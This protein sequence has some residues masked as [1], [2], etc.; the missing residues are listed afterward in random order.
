[1]GN[2]EETYLFLKQ[3]SQKRHLPQGSMVA[4]E[5]VRT[6]DLVVSRSEV[7]FDFENK[8]FAREEVEFSNR[9]GRA[10]I[11]AG[12]T[13]EGLDAGSLV[14]ERVAFPLIVPAGR[15][16]GVSIVADK[17]KL[18]E[19]QS[20]GS[21]HFEIYEEQHGGDRGERMD[22][23]LT[24][25]YRIPISGGP[26]LHI[27]EQYQTIDCGVLPR[28]RSHKFTHIQPGAANV[29]LVVAGDEEYRDPIPLQKVDDVFS[30]A[31]A[32]DDGVH[33]YYFDVDGKRVLDSN[34]S[35]QRVSPGF[36][37]VSEIVL[38]RFHRDFVIENI[39]TRA[40]DYMVRANEP[41][42]KVDTME[43]SLAP[44]ELRTVAFEIIPDKFRSRKNEGFI[45][46]ISNTSDVDGKQKSIRV[47]AE[48]EVIGPH[49]KVVG[50]STLSF[51]SV[52]RGAKVERKLRL[53]NDGDER[54]DIS[55]V[56]SDYVV[57]GEKIVLSPGEERDVSLTLDSS[58]IEQAGPREWGISL[59]SNSVP[60]PHHIR[61]VECDAAIVTL[62]YSTNTKPP[63]EVFAGETHEC[64]IQFE[65]S[66]SE[67]VSIQFDEKQ[68]RGAL[69]VTKVSPQIIGVK[70]G[71]KRER[72]GQKAQSREVIV[73]DALS[74]VLECRVILQYTVV[75]ARAEG[76]FLSKKTLRSRS[77][78]TIRIKIKNSSDEK[79]KIFKVTRKSSNAFG[80]G[81]T[82]QVL[83]VEKNILDPREQTEASYAVPS[84]L[85]EQ[86]IHYRKMRECIEIESNDASGE[87]VAFEQEFTFQPFFDR[88]KRRVAAAAAAL[89]CMAAVGLVM[90]CLG[91]G[92][93][94][95]PANFMR[96][97]QGSLYNFKGLRMA[98]NEGGVVSG[99]A[100]GFS[101]FIN[102]F[103]AVA[104]EQG[105]DSIDVY[106]QRAQLI[107]D[108]RMLADGTLNQRQVDSI[109][110][111]RDCSRIAS[112]PFPAKGG[113]EL[114]AKLI[115]RLKNE[116]EK[117]NN[118]VSQLLSDATRTASRDEEART[119]LNKTTDMLQFSTC[120]GLT[121]VA[122]AALRVQTVALEKKINA[123]YY[124][125]FVGVPR[126][127]AVSINARPRLNNGEYKFII[128][129]GEQYSYEITNENYY[130]ESGA[131]VSKGNRT[132]EIP[133][134]MK[135][136]E[137]Y[138]FWY[139]AND[140][141][142]Q[143][144]SI[145]TKIAGAVRQL[146]N[147]DPLAPGTYTIHIEFDNGG[148]KDYTVE[149]RPR[150]Q[151]RFTYECDMGK[152]VVTTIPAAKIYVLGDNNEQS[153][154]GSR[155][156]AE[157]SAYY[158]ACRLRLVPI[159]SSYSEKTVGIR[160]S[161]PFEE[162]EFH[163]E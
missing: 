30:V 48:A 47:L 111:E 62:R 77:S 95:T 109:Y 64:F 13:I 102:A 9:G 73:R 59:L 24:I 119:I 103:R 161:K 137:G 108:L 128:N 10:V 78:N 121:D 76:E 154:K 88:V 140:T 57:S 54:L 43:K 40:L 36:G 129:E 160:V 74:D 144:L 157:F 126:G 116:I 18:R 29:R 50:D 80:G 37:N 127:S 136:R 38:R 2:P 91:A 26:M 63:F 114:Q 112:T 122:I 60:H 35:L 55:I 104:S 69:K 12:Y 33:H 106:L 85:G 75:A 84:T 120:V 101:S 44:G 4:I 53:L 79:L 151:T 153:L 147:N 6:S 124:V 28:Y 3:L 61:N 133:I 31:L 94:P 68:Y 130:S 123:T 23:M 156:Y 89:V 32:L 143:I 159:L 138:A 113:R 81:E 71:A 135:E 162:F 100:V 134:R 97:L 96:Q 86:L 92:I 139:P 67:K 46:I 70:F 16:A 117:K 132:K 131:F 155:G 115:D 51:G 146:K 125:L 1:M 105:R 87:I 34:N 152:V 52:L 42:L 141:Q 19:L 11:V 150:Q 72:V 82:A 83:P 22:V 41:W 27:H 158:G 39:G 163:L 5:P 99:D 118:Q 93:Q 56:D 148:E 145:S 25:R 45:N 65:R 8:R 142:P 149:I 66:D 58:P 98:Y 15:T 17:G 14:V 107:G 49:L 110:A 7:D 20:A 90:Y 21:L